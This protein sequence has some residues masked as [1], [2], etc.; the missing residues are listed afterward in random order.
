MANTLQVFWPSNT[1]VLQILSSTAKYGIS[2]IRVNHPSQGG[3]IIVD[4]Y[5]SVGNNK[6]Y[7]ASFSSIQ[8]TIN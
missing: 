3:H 8:I 5:N 1:I 6:R 4:V 2:N 7:L